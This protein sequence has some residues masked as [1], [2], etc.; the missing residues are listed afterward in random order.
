[1]S[2]IVII[3]REEDLQAW[4]EKRGLTI[5]VR[6]N[7][8]GW[9]ADFLDPY[10]VAGDAPIPAG[11]DPAQA[12]EHFVNALFGARL[13]DAMGGNREVVPRFTGIATAIAGARRS[14]KELR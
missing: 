5:L 10:L 1:M 3:E 7:N 14:N 9:S 11:S 8:I 2:N 13:T 12:V 4:L 6:K